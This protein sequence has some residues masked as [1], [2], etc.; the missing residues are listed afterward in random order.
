MQISWQNGIYGNWSTGTDWGGSVPGGGDDAV[1]GVSGSYVVTISAPIIAVNSLDIS[2]FDA[3]LYIPDV[4]TG[5][6]SGDLTNGGDLSVANGSAVTVGG[7]LINSSY[8]Y[9]YLTGQGTMLLADGLNNTGSIDLIGTLDT[10]DITAP[11]PASLTGSIEVSNKDLLE[12]A[13]AGITSIASGAYLLLDG[14]QAFVADSGSTGS[15][16]ALTGLSSNA[17]SFYL[18]DGAALTT[19]AGLT[20]SSIISVDGSY[21]NGGSALTVG[22]TLTNTDAITIGNSDITQVTTVTAAGLSNSGTID[23]QGSTNVQ[24][25]L[26]ITTDAGFGTAGVLTGY[27]NLSG[28][29]LLEF[30]RGSI[31]GTAGES[32]LSI[33]GGQ[34][35]VA[36]A[37]N[38]HSESALSG[39]SSN[40]GIFSLADGASFTTSAGFTNAAYSINTGFGTLSG[41]GQLNVDASGLGG[42]TLTVNGTL[43]GPGTTDI[44]NSNI[45]QATTVTVEG[46]ADSVNLTGSYSGSYYTGEMPGTVRA[47]LNVTGAAAPT[48]L[49]NSISITGNALLEFAG[50]GITSIA[51]GVGLSIDGTQ[52]FLADSGNTSS[53]SALTGLSSVAGAFSLADGAALTTTAGFLNTGTLN[54]DASGGGGSTLTVNGTLS[55]SGTVNIGNYLITQATAVM[56]TG[57]VTDGTINLYGSYT[58]NYVPGTTQATLDITAGAAPTTLLGT[59]NIDGDALLEFESGGIATIA[60]GAQLSLNGSEAFL[61]DVG[62]TGSNSALTG[63]SLNLGTFQLS[64]GGAL[65]TTGNLTNVGEFG[66]DSGAGLTLGGTLTNFGSVNVDDNYSG[67][68]QTTMTAAGLTNY[69]SVNLGSSPS[70]K[71]VL[72]ITAAAPTTLTGTVNLNNPY[73]GGSGGAAVLDFQSGGISTIGAGA[74]LM[75][76]DPQSFLA[77]GNQTSGNSAL[78]GLSRNDGSFLLWSGASVTTTTDFLNTAALYLDNPHYGGSSLTIGGTLTS[79]ETI[80][81]GA[82]DSPAPTTLTAGGLNN[83]GWIWLD[84]SSATNTGTLTVNGNATNDG[85]VNID[86]NSN[87]KVTGSYSQNAGF[88]TVT[89]AL[90]AGSVTMA[91]GEID[92]AGTL[93]ATG[94]LTLTAGDIEG[95]GTIAGNVTETGGLLI[96]GPPPAISRIPSA[97]TIRPPRA[98]SP[99]TAISPRAA[100]R[101]SSFCAAARPARASIP[102]R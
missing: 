94:G 35:F 98:R 93:T 76:D 53:N 88:T 31:T 10:L 4:D 70:E 101:S 16:S 23:L 41:E 44:G 33:D 85:T 73:W 82:T 6:T 74:S 48:T 66:D 56:A 83:F 19:T 86:R 14:A 13:S 5:L 21:T 15:N 39:F 57:L 65:T 25:T 89:D 38:T 61:A 79:Y 28:D 27:V 40:A 45:A 9:V 36:D 17:G 32:E 63:L 78:A 96:G 20:N 80:N 92:V 97:S 18:D 95:A 52:A 11:A 69:G 91:G 67:I 102:S 22:G 47:T 55:N 72:D 24:A 64:W 100:A 29:S 49:T 87:L 26:D 43:A 37:G 2:N 3:E 46:L 7:T 68:S 12:F 71:A 90:T 99:S 30:A 34:S 77:V 62:Q 81:V 42:S 59:V 75:L 58:G 51:T 50:G 84:G 1:I 8:G 54:V 60:S